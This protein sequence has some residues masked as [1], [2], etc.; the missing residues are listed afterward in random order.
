MKRTTRSFEIADPFYTAL[1]TM[2]R[3]MNIDRDTLVNQALF[4]LAK[5]HGFIVP[6][7]VSL[8]ASPGVAAPAR[9][10]PPVAD[11]EVTAP[12]R[13]VQPAPM[14]AEPEHVRD[15]A[16]T[17]PEANLSSAPTTV[18]PSLANASVNPAVSSPAPI[19]TPPV[20]TASK[21]A[22]DIA[23]LRAAEI[24]RMEKIAEDVE[25]MVAPVEGSNDDDSSDDD[26]S[27]DDASAGGDEASENSGDHEQPSESAADE[28]HAHRDRDADT[29]AEPISGGA[30]HPSATA[31]DDVEPTVDRTVMVRPSASLKVWVQGDDGGEI[32]VV[33][34]RFVI[35]RGDNCNLVIDSLRVSREHA[36]VQIVG[37]E[38]IIEDLGSSNGTWYNGEK[39]DRR[40]VVNGDEIV[41]GNERVRFRIEG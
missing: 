26:S 32:S 22:V 36:S 18:A 9:P 35:G 38:V 6:T 16:P 2:S 29:Q 40:L 21:P 12:R 4:A 8:D 39:V 30:P 33:P 3:E 31:H 37:E 28:E 23:A 14:L 13:A 1:E 24:E 17:A 19:S 7:V 25:S 41:L 15:A 10:P 34:G 27:D 5:I 20:A 11:L